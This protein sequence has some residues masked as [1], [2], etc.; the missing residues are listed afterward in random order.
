[1][2]WRHIDLVVMASA[3]WTF[4]SAKLNWSHISWSESAGGCRE[5]LGGGLL[6]TPGL[7]K[8]PWPRLMLG[9]EIERISQMGRRVSIWVLLLVGQ[10]KED[11]NYSHNTALLC[12]QPLTTAALLWGTLPNCDCSAERTGI[13][14]LWSETPSPHSQAQCIEYCCHLLVFTHWLNIHLRKTLGLPAKW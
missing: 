11:W 9:N 13:L 3:I 2:S 14:H 4:P 5:G 8:W 7:G 1:M 12:W 6:S 10:G